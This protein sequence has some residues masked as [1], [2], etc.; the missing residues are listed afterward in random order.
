MT[1]AEEL[2]KKLMAGDSETAA[3]VDDANKGRKKAARDWVQHYI[4][5]AKFLNELES[6]PTSQEELETLLIQSWEDK[7]HGRAD[8]FNALMGN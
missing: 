5:I 6:K 3:S 2:A 7:A 1:K 8:E 4:S